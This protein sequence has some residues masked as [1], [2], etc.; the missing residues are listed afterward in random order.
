MASLTTLPSPSPP[1]SPSLPKKKRK[2]KLPRGRHPGSSSIS[3]RSRSP[4]RT[5]RQIIGK[6]G[7]IKLCR[8]E[9][10]PSHTSA[11]AS[12]VTIQNKFL[13]MMGWVNNEIELEE[14]EQV[15]PDNLSKLLAC[16]N[17]HDY[18]EPL[19]KRD[20]RDGYYT[21]EE[22]NKVITDLL[23]HHDSISGCECIAHKAID[24]FENRECRDK[25]RCLIRT[26]TKMNNDR[27][28]TF[29]LSLVSLI[30]CYS[31]NNDITISWAAQGTEFAVSY[32]LMDTHTSEKQAFKGWPDFCL[33]KDAVGAGIVLVIIGEVESQGDFFSQLGIYTVGQFR[34][35]TMKS[36]KLGG[37]GIHKDKMVNLAICT[38]NEEDIVNFQFVHTA[39]QI[40]LQQSS[41]IKK[42]ANLLLATINYVLK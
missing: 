10:P 33:T 7:P 4:I 30:L 6:P 19:Y 37:I 28:K 40:N 42:F 24:S 35:K 26:P 12:D 9:S 32:V 31:G 38:I 13:K 21:K 14:N 8:D 17:Q 27:G 15:I 41:G 18:V 1:P 34:S 29:V 22:S 16:A 2:E 5:R 20:V 39:S 36:K 23:N 11:A 3:S 25:F